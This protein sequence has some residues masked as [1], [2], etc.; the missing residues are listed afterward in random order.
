[1]GLQIIL[2]KDNRRLLR[3]ILWAIAKPLPWWIFT[4]YI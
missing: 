1:V 3:S 2:T 4:A